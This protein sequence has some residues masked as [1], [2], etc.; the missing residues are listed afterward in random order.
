MRL[1]GIFFSFWHETGDRIYRWHVLFFCCLIA[2]C[3]AAFFIGAVP[4]RGFGHDIFF[5]LDNGW[6]VVMGNLRT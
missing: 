5:L 2:I 3:G 6:R 1:Y 4:T